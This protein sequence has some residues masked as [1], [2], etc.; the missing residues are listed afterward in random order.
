MKGMMQARNQAMGPKSKEIV[1]KRTMNSS[2]Q[3]SQ[4]VMSHKCPK[5]L[6]ASTIN[7]RR[8]TKKFSDPIIFSKSIHLVHTKITCQT[9]FFVTYSLLDI[10]ANTN[11]WI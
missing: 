7:N 11:V 1:V 4:V 6:C 3:V 5:N 9:P 8:T 2:H 10:L